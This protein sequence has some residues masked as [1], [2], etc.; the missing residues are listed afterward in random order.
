LKFTG[1][2][3]S[4]ARRNGVL[5]RFGAEAYERH[6]IAQLQRTGRRERRIFAEAVSG[7]DPRIRS[8]GSEPGAPRR[9]AGG[10]HRGL[11]VP[12]QIERFGRTFFD[13]LPEVFAQRRRCLVE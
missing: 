12:C 8:S 13:E 10:Q 1:S 6:R 4:D 11:R 5:H 3:T 2:T 7:N 9:E